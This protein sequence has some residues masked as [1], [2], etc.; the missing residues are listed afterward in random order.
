METPNVETSCEHWKYSA[1]LVMAAVWIDEQNAT[2]AVIPSTM[3]VH[4]HF[5]PAL[6]LSGF[7][8]SVKVM[9]SIAPAFS[10]S[11]GRAEGA[12]ALPEDSGLDVMIASTK[13]RLYPPPSCLTIPFKV[14]LLLSPLMFFLRDVGCR[15]QASFHGSRTGW[16]GMQW[17]V[18][19]NE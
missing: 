5:R 3:M 13:I 19:A 18:A 4:S 16:G 11:R 8:D 10:I 12:M 15:D 7:S 14:K 2:V 6:Q 9:L 17:K 1:T